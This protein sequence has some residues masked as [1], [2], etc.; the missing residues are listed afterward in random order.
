MNA[1]MVPPRSTNGRQL[2]FFIAQNRSHLLEQSQ[3]SPKTYFVLLLQFRISTHSPKGYEYQKEE[4]PSTN[5][6][7]IFR[8]F[9]FDFPFPIL[10]CHTGESQ[11][12]NGAC[13]HKAIRETSH[14]F[15]EFLPLL[16]VFVPRWGE[17]LR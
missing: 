15:H 7:Q 10:S 5:S 9:S 3:S 12:D 6:L 11:N 16:F 17:T 8:R 4:L 2:D 14:H 1:R 13:M